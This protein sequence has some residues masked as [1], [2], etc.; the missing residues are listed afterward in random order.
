MVWQSFIYFQRRYD[1]DLLEQLRLSQRQREIMTIKYVE[2]NELSDLILFK[3]S[4]N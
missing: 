4:C 2:N 3:V 1:T